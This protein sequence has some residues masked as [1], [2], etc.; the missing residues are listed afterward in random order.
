MSQS[1]NRINNRYFSSLEYITEVEGLLRCDHVIGTF[2]N[3]MYYIS[4]KNT[5]LNK[6][7]EVFDYGKN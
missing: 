4:I 5:Q 1:S 6:K 7:I 3:A 2:T